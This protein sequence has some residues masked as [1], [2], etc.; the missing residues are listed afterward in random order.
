[1][2]SSNGAGHKPNSSTAA[3]SAEST[4]NSRPSRSFNAATLSFATS[5][6]ITRLTS[7]SVSGA[8]STSVVPARKA[9]QTLALNDARM[10]KNSPTNP[11]VPGNPAFAI[12][13]NTMND[14]NIG[15][16]LTTPP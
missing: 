6:K 2:T 1:M 16:V 13:N 9:Y 14:A 12:A 4:K 10:T 5:P 11:E 15:M 3:A 8:P 7:H